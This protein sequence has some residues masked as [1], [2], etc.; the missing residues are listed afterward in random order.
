M[1]TAPE[2]IVHVPL[3]L[4]GNTSAIALFL[5][6][7]IKKAEPSR[8]EFWIVLPEYLLAH[9]L[10]MCAV[11]LVYEDCT[12]ISCKL[13]R[14]D[15]PDDALAKLF[16]AD[17]PHDVLAKLL[18]SHWTNLKQMPYF[19]LQFDQLEPKDLLD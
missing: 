4:R 13:F 12:C 8:Q 19:W 15:R 6:A 3:I 1:F 5:I 17:R 18:R 16:R 11:K 9:T 14:A 10:P 7:Y 2:Q